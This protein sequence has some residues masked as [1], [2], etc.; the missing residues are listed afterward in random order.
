MPLNEDG[1]SDFTDMSYSY[2][3]LANSSQG[4]LLNQTHLITFSALSFF[5]ISKIKVISVMMEGQK[6]REPF[7][8]SPPTSNSVIFLNIYIQIYSHNKNKSS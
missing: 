8:F 2:T 5:Q 6:Q 3:L 1:T 4:I 7:I